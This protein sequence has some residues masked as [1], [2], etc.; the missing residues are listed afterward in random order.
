MNSVK[1]PQCGLVNWSENTDCKRCGT[2]LNADYQPLE[3][4]YQPRTDYSIPAPQEKPIFSGGINLLF[5]VLGLAAVMWLAQ[6]L[7]HPF[8]QDLAKLIAACFALA[9][10]ALLVVAHLWLL[11]RIFEQSVGWGLASLCIPIAML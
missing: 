7:L 9:G 6:A 11:V 2:S 8:P 5:G 3:N 1:C 4:D 10:L